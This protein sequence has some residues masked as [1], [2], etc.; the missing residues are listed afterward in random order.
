[1]VNRG[2]NRPSYERASERLDQAIELCRG[3]GFGLRFP[4]PMQGIVAID[5]DLAGP[6]QELAGRAELRASEILLHG[7]TLPS[8]S[9]SQRSLT[10]MRFASPGVAPTALRC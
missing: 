4:E 2:G 5:I 7:T 9:R 10:R 8:C 1:M 6:I 3:S